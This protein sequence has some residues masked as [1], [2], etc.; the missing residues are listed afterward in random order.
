[1]VYDYKL[2]L[3]IR[4]PQACLWEQSVNGVDRYFIELPEIHFVSKIF[5]CMSAFQAPY[6]AVLV[7]LYEYAIQSENEM[8]CNR[9]KEVF[10][11]Q[12]ADLPNR[13]R[14]LGLDDSLVS[15]SYVINISSLRDRIKK[16]KDANP[17]LHYHQD[18][19]E[20]LKNIMTEISM[21]TRMNE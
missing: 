4:T 19:E 3:A 21:I 12:F 15:S 7:S 2:H 10:D 16:A 17:E 5:Y 9:I 8:L 11:L 14:M 1:M 6:K 18:N 13:F 20:Y